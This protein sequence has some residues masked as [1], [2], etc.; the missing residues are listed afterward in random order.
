MADIF[1]SYANEDREKARA[2]AGLLE[3]AGCTVWW[4]R[5]IPAG[6][7]WRS[8]IEEA[9][10]DMRCMV[11]LWSTHSVG[12]DWVKEEAEEARALGRL[13]PVLIEPVKPPV[14][15][16]SIQAADLTDWD[17]SKD[18]LGARQL[19][20]D[21]ESLMGKS[22]SRKLSDFEEVPR[23][24]QPIPE[25]SI[26]GTHAVDRS[27]EESSRL[28][29]RPS[30]RRM[31]STSI[32]SGRKLP[33]WWKKAVAGVFIVIAVLGSLLWF[34]KRD[35]RAPALEISKVNPARAPVPTPTLVSLG[36][37]GDRQEVAANETLNVTLKG[38]YSDGTQKPI[39]EGIQW[40]SSEPRVATIDDQGRVT[41]RQPGETKIT[42]RYGAIVSPV[43]ILA[44]RAEKPSLTLT[45]PTEPPVTQSPAAT[46][47][48]SLTVS[49]NNR[50]IKIRERLLLLVKA[51]YSDGKEKGLSSG[52]EWRSSDRSVATIDSRGELLALRVGKIAVV[53]RWGGIESVA[54]D[55]VIKEPAS[56]PLPEPPTST[57]VVEPPP[58]PP[59]K[60]AV[61]SVN[62]ASYINRAKGYRVQGNYAAA[63]A[64]LEKARAVNPGSQEVID[65]IEATRRACNAEQRLGREGLT[66]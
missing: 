58:V 34:G 59:T 26:E 1:L 45:T 52:V 7:T 40:L 57:P 29:A 17:G 55:I 25:P 27:T 4:D 66:C 22:P 2:V 28:S 48:V 63:L 60:P 19:I 65:E 64:E 21:L 23:E 51:R 32:V 33:G 44:V 31:G 49:A 5:R 62:L 61:Q 30:I 10:R 47:L 11:V 8:M 54:V 9:L 13:I 15:F 41:A 6:R 56:K 18:S 43:W 38:Q 14:G 36:L 35:R 24:K 39:Y 37:S 3:S 53:A 20:A 46:K 50:E 16:R 12:S 42:A